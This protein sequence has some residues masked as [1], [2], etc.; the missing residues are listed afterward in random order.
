MSGLILEKIEIDLPDYSGYVFYVLKAIEGIM[1][2]LLFEK[3]INIDRTFNVFKDNIEPFK[4][5]NAI[6]IKINCGKTTLVIENLYDFYKK[7]RHTLFHTEF[8][9][10]S[11]R[12]LEKREFAIDILNN[13]LNLINDSY[14]NLFNK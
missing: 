13:S 7:E 6:N 1:K 2:H 10:V 14:H 4:L 11:T 12:I 8:L 3:G 5:K 9:D